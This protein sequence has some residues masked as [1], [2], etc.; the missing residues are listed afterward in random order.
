MNK[1]IINCEQD[2]FETCKFLQVG[3]GHQHF[4]NFINLDISDNCKPDVQW[5]ITKGFS[6]FE[7]N[8]FDEVVAN[9]VLEIV[10]SNKDLVYVMNEIW[11]ILKSGGQ[12]NGQVPG[13]K[14]ED[15]NL[16]NIFYDPF[17][18]RFF[19]KDSFRYW[20]INEHAYNEFGKMY[21]FS[22][23]HVIKCEFNENI[24][25]CFRMLPANK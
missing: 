5:D 24:I 12:F 11:R 1:P 17:D 20:T 19:Q 10:E 14:P 16:K 3:C 22:P 13:F 9:G 2:K 7:D 4:N 6:F 21:G 15:N 8:R 25:L 23:W 18:R